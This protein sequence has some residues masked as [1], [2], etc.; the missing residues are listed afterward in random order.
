MRPMVFSS[1][2]VV[3]R[4]RLWIAFGYPI[5]ISTGKIVVPIPVRSPHAGEIH[6]HE[7]GR[8]FSITTSGALTSSWVAIGSVVV[9]CAL[10][11][12]A[13][14]IIFNTGQVTPH[15]GRVFIQVCALGHSRHGYG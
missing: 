1:N 14:G 10:S 3:V 6:P 12:A 9:V 13:T 4:G 7:L 5:I 11:I 8:L 2:V 15:A